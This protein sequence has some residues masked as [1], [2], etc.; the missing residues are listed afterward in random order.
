MY[1]LLNSVKAFFRFFLSRYQPVYFVLTVF[2]V[3]NP[4]TGDVTFDRSL[5]YFTSFESAQKYAED[6]K[7][8]FEL[9]ILD[10]LIFKSTEVLKNDF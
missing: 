7:L 5:E 2:K 4:K 1:K 10:Q 9:D 8:S 3:I 6:I